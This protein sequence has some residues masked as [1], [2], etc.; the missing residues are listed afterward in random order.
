MFTCTC[1]INCTNCK[2]ER[3]TDC[4]PTAVMITSSSA[5]HKHSYWCQCMALCTNLEHGVDLVIAVRLRQ[6]T[7]DHSKKPSA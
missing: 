2:Q 3:K 4:T 7:D 5:Q 1:V 6:C